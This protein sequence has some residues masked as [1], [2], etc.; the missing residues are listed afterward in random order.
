MRLPKWMSFFRRLFKRPE[1]QW[2]YSGKLPSD[3]HPQ[4]TAKAGNRMQR[5]RDACLARRKNH[6]RRKAKAKLRAEFLARIK[7]PRS[8]VLARMTNS[9]ITGWQRSGRKEETLEILA[10]HWGLS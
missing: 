9:Q 8:R 3:P 6:A 5:R 4:K 1:P 2:A 7:A 10:K